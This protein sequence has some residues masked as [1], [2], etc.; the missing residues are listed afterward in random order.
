MI[1]AASACVRA[2]PRP[3]TNTATPA[4][5]ALRMRGRSNS[6]APL[7]VFD[8]P[9][10][11]A[12]AVD[13]AAR[14][15]R[16]RRV[17]SA[18]GRGTRSPGPPTPSCMISRA[19]NRA[20]ASTG[21]S[22][23]L[24]NASSRASRRSRSLGT[25]F[26]MRAYLNCFVLSGQKR[27]LRPH[28]VCRVS[29][30]APHH[31]NTTVRHACAQTVRFAALGPTNPA[32]THHRADAP[33]LITLDLRTWEGVDGLRTLKTSEAAALLSVT[34]NTL[35]TWERRFGYPNPQRLPGRHRLYA[36]A[37]VAAL[38]EALEGG[39][40]ISSAV[41]VVC[42]AFGAEAHA[43]LAALGSFRGDEADNAMEGSLALRP[44]ER[45]VQEVLL[46]ALDE[47]HRRKGVASAAHGRSPRRG[48]TIGCGGHSGWRLRRRTIRDL[49]IGDATNADLDPASAYTRALALCCA[50]Q[51]ISVLTLPVCAFRRIAEA[52]AVSNPDV[53]VIA[54]GYSG[55]RGGSVGLC[56]SLVGR[57][58]PV[59]AVPPRA[60]PGDLRCPCPH[61][62]PRAN[63]RAASHRADGICRGRGRAHAAPVARTGSAAR[64]ATHRGPVNGAT[65]R[66]RAPTVVVL[67][68][69]LALAALVVAGCG[70]AVD[71]AGA[72]RAPPTASSGGGATKLSL[73]A[74]ST[75]QVVYDEII[76]GFQKTRGGQGRRVQ[77]VLRRLRRPEPRGRGRPDGRRRRRSRSSP[78]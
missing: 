12:V 62:A 41:S 72:V 36:Y 49:F 74:Y 32:R 15:Q 37:E 53:V 25:I 71:D 9:G 47:V 68:L 59:H 34:P 69:A 63:E 28:Y 52:I 24:A 51:G 11:V 6:I 78:T 50:R 56:R 7:V 1:N 61:P 40:T 13:R 30:T 2:T 4:P 48:V 31:H 73:V 64:G 54:G 3:S 66:M 67:T 65:H 55:E 46:P 35:R 38:R 5:L 19:P 33:R 21:S 44:L 29:G 23:T 58:N 45:S 27:R 76:P 26:A 20:A 39:L 18:R 8:R 70:G 57:R 14:R 10:L 75:P 60:Q 42:E 22:C 17:P 77:E 43:V 16:P